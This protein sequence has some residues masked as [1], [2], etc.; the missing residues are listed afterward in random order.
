MEIEDLWQSHRGVSHASNF[1]S[2]CTARPPGPECTTIATAPS[3]REAGSSLRS[4]GFEDQRQSTKSTCEQSFRFP[5]KQSR[6]VPSE[7]RRRD[8]PGRRLL[9]LP[10][11]QLE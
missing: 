4:V 5:P 6:Q 9:K 8:H 11:T 7:V 10:A 2:A 3:T 1:R